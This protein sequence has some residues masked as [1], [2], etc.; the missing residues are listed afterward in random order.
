MGA[1]A[2][3]LRTALEAADTTRAAVMSGTLAVV[4]VGLG[5]FQW[6]RFQ[7]RSFVDPLEPAL[8]LLTVLAAVGGL[9]VF[10]S[11]RSD[12]P[13]YLPLTGGFALLGIG[14]VVDVMD[15]FLFQPSPFNIVFESVASGLAIVC[16]LVALSRWAERVDERET[17]LRRRNERLDDFASIASHDLRNPL[18]VAHGGLAAIRRDGDAAALDRLERAITRM[19]TIVD[20]VLQFSRI[21]ADSIEPQPVQLSDVAS[22]AWDAIQADEATLRVEADGTLLADR[23]LLQQALENLFRN[24]MD[25]GGD[26]VTIWIG[27]TMNGFY[28]MDDGPGIDTDERD[29]VFESGYSGDV[30]TGL[31]LAIVSRIVEAHDWS[32]RTVT[33]HDA[34]ARFEVRVD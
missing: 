26:D 6:T 19:D 33:G 34:G 3:Q 29:Q 17:E 2:S 5:Y 4:L 12:P 9:V 22:K 32:I 24:A 27:A 23:R 25:H 16:F 21:G 13:I 30:S 1:V 10:D 20:D 15:D 31:G 7:H 8:E 14:G 11:V 28:V 18:Q